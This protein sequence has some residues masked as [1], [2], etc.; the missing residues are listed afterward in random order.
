MRSSE[1]WRDP[2][3]ISSPHGDP[4]AFPP[5]KRDPGGPVKAG[6]P[7]RRLANVGG[8]RRFLTPLLSNNNG[9]FRP[10]F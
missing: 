3:G 4:R 10:R 6:R 9:G 8:T 5:A 7:L 2:S 1:P